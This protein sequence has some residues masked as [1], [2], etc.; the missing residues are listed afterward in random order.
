MFIN[1]LKYIVTRNKDDLR[2]PVKRNWGTQRTCY[3]A[4]KDWNHLDRDLRNLCTLSDFRC[5]FLESFSVMKFI[6]LLCT[7]LVL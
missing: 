2:L 6:F 5:I 7:I 1:A 3:H 4:L